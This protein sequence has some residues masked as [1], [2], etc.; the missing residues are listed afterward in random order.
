MHLLHLHTSGVALPLAWEASSSLTL[1]AAAAV[2]SAAT[3]WEAALGEGAEEEAAAAGSGPA[4][5]ASP[6]CPCLLP[7]QA[8]RPVGCAPVSWQGSGAAEWA[9]QRGCH[10]R[11]EQRF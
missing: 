10:R 11:V 3:G 1:E 2:D 5:M 7:T 6:A 9:Q 8:G 4:L